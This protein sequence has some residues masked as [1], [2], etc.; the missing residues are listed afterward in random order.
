MLVVF[1]FCGG[2][3]NKGKVN[4]KNLWRHNLRN[5]PYQYTYYPIAQISIGKQTMKFGQLIEYK[6]NN[7]FLKTSYTK[8]GVETIFR[9]FS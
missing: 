9:P 3:K 4:F 5:K 8:R 2:H 6:K 1:Y 7:T